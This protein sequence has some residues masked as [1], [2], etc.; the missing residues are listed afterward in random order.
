MSPIPFEFDRSISNTENQYIG[1]QAD[2]I[3]VLILTANSNTFN[4]L[5]ADSRLEPTFLP[6]TTKFN[7]H[8]EHELL[9]LDLNGVKATTPLYEWLEGLYQQFKGQIVAVIP[10]YNIEEKTQLLDCGI[11]DYLDIEALS[12]ESLY[13]VVLKCAKRKASPWQNFLQQVIDVNPNLIFVKNTQGQ[14]VL[15]NEALARRHNLERESFIGKTDLELIEGLGQEEAIAYMEQDRKLLEHKGDLSFPEEVIKDEQGNDR[16]IKTVK[17]V[18]FDEQGEAKHILGISMDITTMRQAEKELRQAY[19]VIENSPLIFF[20]CTTQGSGETLEFD[21]LSKNMKRYGF[22]SEELINGSINFLE[23]V[24]HP[25][26]IE[27]IQKFLRKSVKEGHHEF[28]IPFRIFTKDRTIRWLEATILVQEGNESHIHQSQGFFLDITDKKNNEAELQ[29]LIKKIEYQASHDDLTRLPNRRLFDEHITQSINY[30]KHSQKRAAILF[31]KL[32][33]F[34]MANETYGQTKADGVFIEVVKRFQTIT[35]EIDSMARIDGAK[36]AVLINNLESKEEAKNVA[37]RYLSCLESVFYIDNEEV[38]INANIGITCYP[39]D[40]QTPQILINHAEI[41]MDFSKQN[42]ANTIQLFTQTL[43]NEA[44]ELAAIESSLRLAVERKEFLLHYQPQISFDTGRIVGVEAL[45]RWERPEKG[46][47]PPG[48]F[49][50]VAEETLLI[51]DI[52]KWVLFESCAQAARWHKQGFPMTIAVNVAAPQFVHENFVETVKIAL[53]S[54]GLDARY[55]EIEVTEGVVMHNISFVA[56]RLQEIRDLGVSIALDDFGTGFS[57]LKYLQTLPCDKLKIDRSF[58]MNIGLAQDDS[59]DRALVENIMR[60]GN[61]F[62]LKIIAEGI[63]TEEQADY[64]QALGCE[65]AQGFYYAR[66]VPA[67]EVI[68]DGD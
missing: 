4:F 9:I 39:E 23:D 30:A 57:S 38:V 55:L 47:V 67:S 12:A 64:L 28:Q 8:F 2:R 32:T 54:S 3:S 5:E 49:I 18:L 27:N 34:K 21:F 22:V 13:E 16:F 29:G 59:G 1:T 46:L 43:V 35:R 40:G 10:P 41:A 44:R 45:L 17:R 50:S 66:P 58:I 31:I 26:D 42:G 11:T 25:E 60:L 52:G 33:G 7:Q 36:I 63:E 65:Y 62:N 51:I 20:K 48:K 68:P 15:V 56:K 53:A 14:Y 6:L 19:M 37:Q 61:S 24:C